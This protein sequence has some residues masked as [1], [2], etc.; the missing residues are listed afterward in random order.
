MSTWRKR[1]V[2]ANGLSQT[3]KWLQ[4]VHFTDTGLQWVVI[5]AKIHL[6]HIAT[7]HTLT[8]WSLFLKLSN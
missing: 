1:V 6:K 2:A 5:V 7:P 3:Q 8:A 4:L